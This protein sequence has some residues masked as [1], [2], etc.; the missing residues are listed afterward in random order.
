MWHFILTSVVKQIQGVHWT[1]GTK[2]DNSTKFYFQGSID[3]EKLIG[4]KSVLFLSS[5]LAAN[6]V[7]T[8]AYIFFGGV[9]KI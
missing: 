3:I 8:A 9:L 6:Q 7:L 1:S 2:T 5:K 4:N